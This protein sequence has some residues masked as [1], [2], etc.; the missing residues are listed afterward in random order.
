MTTGWL[1]TYCNQLWLYENIKNGTLLLLL[2]FCSCRT[3]GL[4][5]PSSP[6]TPQT[7]IP[8]L[9]QL[10]WPPRILLLSWSHWAC[11][12]FFCLLSFCHSFFLLLCLLII[13]HYVCAHIATICVFSATEYLAYIYLPSFTLVSTSAF[14]TLSI[15]LILSILLQIHKCFKSFQPLSIC[16]C[17]SPGLCCM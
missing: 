16:L 1:P 11:P 8:D 3:S 4:W 9:L 14:D 5:L 12:V 17:H 6:C 10:T 15:Q 7:L 2:V 13:L